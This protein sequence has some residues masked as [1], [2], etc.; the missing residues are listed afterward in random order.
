MNKIL[1]HS[2]AELWEFLENSVRQ[3]S[4]APASLGPTPSNI[5]WPGSEPSA[6][7][8]LPIERMTQVVP[9]VALTESDGHQPMGGMSSES[10]A[11]TLGIPALPSPQLLNLCEFLK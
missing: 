10:Q 8:V 3:A 7:S 11:Q 9:E 5:H 2:D 1:K 4:C 6:S